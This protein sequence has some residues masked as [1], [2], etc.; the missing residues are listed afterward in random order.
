[1]HTCENRHEMSRDDRQQCQILLVTSAAT[2]IDAII[3]QLT[4]NII[5]QKQVLQM[6]QVLQIIQ[7][8][9]PVP[10]QIQ[11]PQKRHGIQT[12]L[13]KSKHAIKQILKITTLYSADD[14]VTQDL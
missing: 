3:L 8:P 1:M 9:D 5:C 7:M 13:I 10:A 11:P 14:V 12:L 2:A 4:Y 6:L